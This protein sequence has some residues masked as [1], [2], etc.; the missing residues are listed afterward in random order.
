MRTVTRLAA[1]RREN[2]LL[3]VFV[4]HKVLQQKSAFYP[5]IPDQSEFAQIL[6]W[7]EEQ[8]NV[9]RLSDAVDGLDT[10]ML[11]VRAAAITFDDG[12]G[13]TLDCA[14]P[15]FDQKKIHAT[16]FVN[17]AYLEGGE[18]FFERIFKAIE[19][20]DADSLDL[21]KFGEGIVSLKSP[22]Q[23]R[24]VAD[25]LCDRAKY[26]LPSDA[27]I[28]ANRIVDS[29]RLDASVRMVSTQELLQKRCSW[30]DFGGHSHHHSILTT[31]D[32]DSAEREIQACKRVISDLTG[33][34]TPL[35][36]YPN[37]RPGKDFTPEHETMVRR[38]GFKA[39]F[40]CSHGAMKQS[41]NH[42]SVPRFTA[43]DKTRLKFQMRM[44]M[45]LIRS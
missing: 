35:F 37:G 15:V 24:A 2:G 3:T 33:N 26:M 34:D 10:G 21:T 27:E 32:A 42:F 30:I 29:S 20:V 16:F 45:N 43:W 1:G 40:S 11:P 5:D 22:L 41:D 36:A 19:L 18:P 8:F 4:F 17:T 25:R 23:R 13:E 12:N 39:A 44:L 31:L 38:A 6:D 14:A 28:F 7:I 9:I